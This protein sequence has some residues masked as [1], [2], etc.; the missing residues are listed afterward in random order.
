MTMTRGGSTLPCPTPRTRPIPRDAMASSVST[1][2]DV[3][4]PLASSRARSAKTRGVNRLA[5]S[6]DSSRAVFV[7]AASRAPRRAAASTSASGSR[8]RTSSAPASG[9]LSGSSV[10]KRRS[11]N[12]PSTSPST[13]AWATA[14]ASP[15][16]PQAKATR[17]ALRPRAARAAAPATS[18]ARSAVQASRRPAPT[19]RTR[20]VPQPASTTSVRYSSW[21]L[22]LSSPDAR[23]RPVAPA[24]AESSSCR[25]SLSS[26]SKTGAQSRSA[27]EP[28]NP[29]ERQSTGRTS[30]AVCIGGL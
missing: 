4:G 5:G 29:P 22:P 24:V 18:R 25:S 2:T 30:G 27:R 17:L 6:L 20:R 14:G 23:A 1:S 7:H 13:T 16:R 10:L 21:S 19:R 3:R 12:A 26:F 28:L 9:R 11:R 15:A 8:P